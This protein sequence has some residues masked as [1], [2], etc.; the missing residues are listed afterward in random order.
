MLIIFSDIK[1][2]VH[3]TSW[4]TKQSIPH[5]TVIFYGDC[6]KMFQDFA[7]NFDDKSTGRCIT[8][9]HRPTLRSLPE[10]VLPETT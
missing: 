8:T 5:T 6:V 2:I 9:T 1:A 10:N 4:Q 7:P 3:N